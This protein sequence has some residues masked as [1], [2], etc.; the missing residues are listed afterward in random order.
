MSDNTISL[1]ILS[2][3]WGIPFLCGLI[4]YL[5]ETIC[6]IDIVLKPKEQKKR[7][8]FWLHKRRLYRKLRRFL[9]TYSIFRPTLVFVRY[10]EP[11]SSYRDY[12]FSREE[13]LEQLGYSVRTHQWIKT[14]KIRDG[15][16][17]Q[18]YG[19]LSLGLSGL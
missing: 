15:Y 2:V 18:I 17:V 16:S 13:R 1:I 3:V 8:R 5:G 6:R 11:P 10:Q 9:W 19:N 12:E 14:T 7:T 4:Y